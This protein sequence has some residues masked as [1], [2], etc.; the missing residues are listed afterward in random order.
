MPPR[1]RDALQGG[2]APRHRPQAAPQPPARKPPPE[3][4]P[5][6]PPRPDSEPRA[7]AGSWSA[8]GG[9]RGRRALGAPVPVAAA[10]PQT[11]AGPWARTRPTQRLRCWGPDPPS[12]TVSR[13]P[14]LRP[15][16]PGTAA[17]TSPSGSAVSRVRNRF[18]TARARARAALR[19][20]ARHHAPLSRD[21]G[22]PGWGHWKACV[23]PRARAPPIGPPSP[24]PG[25]RPRARPQARP[26]PPSARAQPTGPPSPALRP[27]PAN[28]PAPP[29]ARAPP[30]PRKLGSW[31]F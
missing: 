3:Q 9:R 19:P 1:V 8:P 2:P 14:A 25:S 10:P 23:P 7:R 28:R 27:G 29:R 31:Y 13:P 4:T 17:L 5:A 11:P 22:A 15:S 18:K 6:S 12:P 26:A 21:P 20:P 16:R 24:A 30:L